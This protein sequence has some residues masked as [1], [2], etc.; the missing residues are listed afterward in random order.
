M[1]L[2]LSGPISDA[3]ELNRATCR[4]VARALRTAGYR[5]WNPVEQVPLGASW[6]EAMRRDLHGLLQC[7]AMALLDDW[8]QARSALLEV[9]VAGALGLSVRPWRDWI[10]D[11][12]TRGGPPG[13][14]GMSS[15]PVSSPATERL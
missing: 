13:G 10:H 11:A 1:L 8:A 3:P 14:H 9:T 15:S 5:V 2:Y 4:E 7:E 6:S 12:W